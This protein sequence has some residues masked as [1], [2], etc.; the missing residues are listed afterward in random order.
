M[1]FITT[2]T[3]VWN[4]S[5][6][7]P[8]VLRGAYD[9]ADCMVV[10]EAC[11]APV[12][13]AG[14]TSSDGTADIVKKFMQ[15]E[16]PEGK[17]RF[18]QA[19][20]IATPEQIA[21]PTGHHMELCAIGRN[22]AIH[23]VP[24]ET[25]HLFL[26]DCDEFYLPEDLFK[27]RRIIDT[28]DAGCMTVQAR[29]FYFDFTYYKVEAFTRVWRWFPG[30]RFVIV[31]SMF[32]INNK[33]TEIPASTL[34]MYHYS[35]VSPEWTRLKGCAGIDLPKEQYLRW[36]KNIFDTFDGTNLEELYAKNSD[37]IHVFGGGKLD[38]YFGIHPPVL[39]KHPLRHKTWQDM[40]NDS[41][42]IDN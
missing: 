36:R 12:D 41:S 7:L 10:G 3:N 31:S 24:P 27:L 23:L 28:D 2:Y 34:M 22:A 32:N 37:G 21:N 29:C 33:T 26:L 4:S 19:G 13:W 39:D 35:Y 30:Q 5:T 17:V 40:L 1:A 8:W 25:T 38:R 16:D 18:H 6:W 20:C 15:E 42:N 9:F 11:W 14:D